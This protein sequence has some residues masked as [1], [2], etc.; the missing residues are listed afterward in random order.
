MSYTGQPTQ[1]PA[2]VVV[3]GATIFV[4]DV[5]NFHEF[6]GKS[7]G[8]TKGGSPSKESSLFRYLR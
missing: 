2:E 8:K 6:K 7:D 5:E 1:L 4:I 3:G